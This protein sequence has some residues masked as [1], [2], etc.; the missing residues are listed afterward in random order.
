MILLPLYYQV[1]RG[2]SALDGRP[3][4][5]A[6]GPRRGGR[7][8]DRRAADRPPRRRAASSLV[9]LI[10]VT[11]RRRSRSRGRRRDTSYALLGAAARPAR[12]RDRLRD[13]AGDGRRLRGARRGRGAARD[14][15]AE[16]PAARRRLA[17]HRA[18]GRRPAGPDIE[19][20]LAGLVPGGRRAGSACQVLTP[21][22]SERSSHRRWP[23]VRHDVLVRDGADAGRPDPGAAAAD[24]PARSR[25]RHSRET[26]SAEEREAVL[27]GYR[28]PTARPDGGPD[29]VY[30]CRHVRTPR[31]P[32]PYRR[33]SSV[34]TP[35]PTG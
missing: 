27:A 26:C 17:R 30:V 10:V 4:D 33:A 12:D 1:V 18:A 7:D 9:G 31:F 24:G 20:N 19:D 21:D 11:A 6:A 32:T 35:S 22:S 5:G 2:E 13:D 25:P 23:G 28:R 3:A 15:R 8:A 16:R 34:C 29:G 14:E